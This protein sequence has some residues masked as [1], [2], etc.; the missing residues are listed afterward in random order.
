MN[1][2]PCKC[3]CGKIAS[4]RAHYLRGHAMRGRKH[5]Q[6]QIAKQAALMVVAHKRGA[7]KESYANKRKKT[8]DGRPKCK[9]GCGKPVSR[10]ESIY[11]SHECANNFSPMRRK[12]RCAAGMPD[13]IFAKE[14]IF[15]GP[16]GKVYK[17]SNL[18]EWARQNDW[19]FEDDRPESKMSFCRRIASGLGGLLKAD[20][21]ACSYRGWT[22]VSK[23]ELEDGG[24][25][26]LERNCEIVGGEFG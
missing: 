21:L 15:R 11:A 4:E 8:L 12:C 7:F 23:L 2:K 10:A 1:C 16:F 5:S 14:W 18:A 13:H 9:C 26:L 17:F 3:G 20:G 25:D 19:R 24:K 6:E 22:A